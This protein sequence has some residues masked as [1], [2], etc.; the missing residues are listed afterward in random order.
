M[1][2]REIERW[3]TIRGARVPIYKGESVKDALNRR[4]VERNEQIKDAQIQKNKDIAD[5]LN[6]KSEKITPVDESIYAQTKRHVDGFWEDLSYAGLPDEWHDPYDTIV[7][8]YSEEEQI[9]MFNRDVVATNAQK[10]ALQDYT[11]G[12]YVS[13]K[14]G[15]ENLTEKYNFSKIIEDSKKLHL[16][17]ATL[18]RGGDI[19]ENDYQKLLKGDANIDYLKGV[20]SW[21]LREDV[22]HMYAQGDISTGGTYRKMLGDNS[23]GHRVIFI[24]ENTNDSMALPFAS[25]H[26]ESLRSKNRSYSISKIIPESEYKG[27]T[28]SRNTAYRA[29]DEPV[30]YVFVKS[31]H[32][33]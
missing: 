12:H 1:T 14:N 30:T 27:I 16:G 5:S 4:V 25:A 23:Q 2:E 31:T 7:P 8:K 26:D 24:E 28:T 11:R 21:S 9:E 18:F 13:E 20:T 19:S 10:K 15:K 33:R 3:V 32:K 29:F 17:N 6:K 22:A